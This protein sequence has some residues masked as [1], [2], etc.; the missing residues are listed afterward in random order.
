MDI[1]VAHIADRTTHER[2]HAREVDGLATSDL[3]FNEGEWILRGVDG[4][5]FPAGVV[6][7]GLLFPGGDNFSWVETNEGVPAQVFPAFDGLEKEARFLAAE[8]GVGGDRGLEIRHQIGIHRH[9]VALAGQFQ[10]FLFWR[11]NVHSTVTDLA[12]LRGFVDIASTF[13]GNIVAEELDGD[14][15]EDG[16]NGLVGIGYRDD[17]VRQ[18]RGEIRAFRG[19]GD[20]LTFPGADFLEVGQG[21]LVHL[22]VID[23]EKARAFFANQGYR[24]VFHL[25]GRV[26]FRMDVGDFLELEG[27][28]QGDG[29][30]HL[31]TKE[32]EILRL[33]IF[34]GD[35]LD[36]RSLGEDFFHLPG[37]ALEGG[38]QLQAVP[39]TQVTET[40]QVESHHGRDQ[41]LGGEGFG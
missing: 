36:F 9:D 13:Q 2:G 20:D 31:A 32:K 41:Q 21:L 37:D 39:E 5:G 38:N 40:P 24:S 7:G 10:K 16:L 6:D 34:F 33:G 27:T 26:A 28:F 12:K 8:L 18:I 35:S 19:D 3:S 4:F 1:F 22:I 23:E 29:E 30:H 14:G 11:E 17:I 25:S 15:V